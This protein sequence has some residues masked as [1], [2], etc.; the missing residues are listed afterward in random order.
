MPVGAFG[1]LQGTVIPKAPKSLAALHKITAKGYAY[2][3]LDNA[4]GL[5]K[6][7]TVLECPQDGNM[8]RLPTGGTQSG[9]AAEMRLAEAKF[10]SFAQERARRQQQERF[11]MMHHPKCLVCPDGA[12][13]I[14]NI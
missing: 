3:Q 12:C 7:N 9:R 2:V 11:K 13:D 10:K 8:F 5:V 1:E 14:A 6:E 4:V